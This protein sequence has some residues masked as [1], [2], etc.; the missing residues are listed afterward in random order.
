MYDKALS[1]TFLSALNSSALRSGS[2]VLV[3]G[4]YFV[5]LQNTHVYSSALC[6]GSLVLES[7]LYFVFLQNT[8]V[9]ES[10]AGLADDPCVS[11]AILRNWG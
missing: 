6:S 3:S 7:G 8:H 10:T 2:L 4:L 9:S 5:F 1:F 11:L